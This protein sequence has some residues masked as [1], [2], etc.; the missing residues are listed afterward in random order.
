MALEM[1]IAVDIESSEFVRTIGPLSGTLMASMLDQSSDCV[2]ILDADGRLTFMNRQGRCSL[3]IDDFCAVAGQRWDT[4][5]PEEAR[6]QVNAA[7]VDAQAGKQ[8]RFE[9]FCPS[10][11][12]S[13]RWWDVSV[14]PVSGPDGTLSAIISISRDVTDRHVA[15]EAMATMAQEMRHRLRNAYAIAGAITLASGREEPE[16]A[17]FARSLAQRFATLAI[18]QSKLIDGGGAESLGELIEALVQPFDHGR[19]L[20]TIAP[21]APLTLTEQDARLVALVVAELCT[22]SLKHGAL[23]QDRA[24]AIAVT[25]EPTATPD[26]TRI[27]IDWREAL[28]G[29][30]QESVQGSGQGLMKRMAMAHGGSF[31]LTFGPDVLHARLE[32]AE[33]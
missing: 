29:E 32:L 6:P 23:G 3:E 15:D 12:G 30:T 10:A 24:I 11:K 1:A 28:Q 13:A 27:A 17:D 2:K 14:S 7:I 20:F 22:N 18:A 26:H 19:G 9:A 33:H 8:S 31:Q 4:I 5:W 21:I 16:H 25:C